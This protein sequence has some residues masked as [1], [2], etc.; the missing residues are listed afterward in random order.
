[1][2]TKELIGEMK[3]LLAEKN[4][5]LLVVIYPVSDILED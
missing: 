4:I 2:K 1:V 3:T 5:P